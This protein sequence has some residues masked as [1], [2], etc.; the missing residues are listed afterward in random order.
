MVKI[1]QR[2]AKNTC[3]W[4]PPDQFPSPLSPLTLTWP[5]AGSLDLA[6]APR[7]VVLLHAP[8]RLQLLHL[9]ARCLGDLRQVRGLLSKIEIVEVLGLLVDLLKVGL[10]GRLPDHLV[11]WLVKLLP[12]LSWRVNLYFL[13]PLQKFLSSIWRI[14][15]LRYEAVNK[16]AGKRQTNYTCHLALASRIYHLVLCQRHNFQ[17]HCHNCQHHC[18]IG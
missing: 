8:V 14:V 10:A 4:K 5:T 6:Q 17:Y 1:I 16:T 12:V 2:K 3:W 15:C 7:D 9:P 11:D 13:K 18:T